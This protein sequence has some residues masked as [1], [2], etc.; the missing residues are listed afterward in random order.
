MSMR[1][2]PIWKQ[3]VVDLIE[4]DPKP[5][6]IVTKEWLREH[7]EMTKPPVNDFDAMRTFE[8]KMLDYQQKFFT[9]LE[10]EHSLIF[11]EFDSRT[12]GRRLLAPAEVAEYEDK[13]WRRR[14]SNEIRRTVMRMKST[15]M[16]ALTPLELT[17]HL[18]VLRRRNW[19]KDQLRMTSKAEIPV[20]YFGQDT[21]KLPKKPTD[22]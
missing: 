7:F 14:V 17:R 10:Q 5:G 12:R 8:F 9:A 3:A 19:Q 18:D 4:L 6:H 11:T 20:K 13:A 2:D 15:D 21:K 1:L 16:T 22:D